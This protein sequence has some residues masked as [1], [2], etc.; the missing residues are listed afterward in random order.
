MPRFGRSPVAFSLFVLTALTVCVATARAAEPELNASAVFGYELQQDFAK[1][2]AE[3]LIDRLDSEALRR[4]AYFI[5]GQDELGS[6]ANKSVWNARILPSLYQQ[7]RALKEFNVMNLNRVLLENGDREVEF[8][9]S[10]SQNIWRPIFITLVRRAD[11]KIGIQDLRLLGNSAMSRSLSD[12]LMMLGGAVA[13]VTEGDQEVLE[14]LQK[15]HRATMSTALEEFAGGNDELAFRII[16]G[17]SPE[18]K[19]TSF[20]RDLRNRIALAGEP[21]AMENLR[22]DY[23]H[24]QPEPGDGYWRFLVASGAG[25][26]KAA[27]AA[28]DELMAENH[29]APYL[30]ITKAMLLLQDDKATTALAMATDVYETNPLS[31]GAYAVAVQAAAA[32]K[33]TGTAVGVLQR[34]NAV[35]SVNEIE[36]NLG[37]L[38]KL[39]NFRV[40]REYAAWKQTASSTPISMPQSSEK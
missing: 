15:T 35:A 17:A 8:V 28:I 23:L 5:F 2:G 26:R 22:D 11:G 20:W 24:G 34:W 37:K 21:K 33:Q 14:R 36:Q 30:R 10:N 9:L 16:S 6:E 18:F 38:P 4:R 40:S 32:L 31:V 1:R 13:V 39:E 27:L 25:N 3:A 29:S 7:I 19:T 12:T